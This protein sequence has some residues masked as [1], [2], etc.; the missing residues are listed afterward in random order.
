MHRTCYGDD[1]VSVGHHW[2]AR[3]RVV[4][5]TRERWA[6]R[7]DFRGKPFTAH[8]RFYDAWYDPRGRVLR[9]QDGN[10]WTKMFVHPSQLT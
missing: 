5:R 8:A 10:V 3:A 6:L 1:E 4:E 9:W 7:V 2:H